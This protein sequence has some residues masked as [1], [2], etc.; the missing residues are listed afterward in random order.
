VYAG[1]VA[2][3]RNELFHGEGCLVRATRFYDPPYFGRAVKSS[4]GQTRA[5]GAE[6]P[7]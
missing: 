3:E 5:I 4:S 1:G 2:D 7:L 6:R